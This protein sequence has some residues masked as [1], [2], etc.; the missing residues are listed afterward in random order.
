[1]KRSR[2]TDE[3]NIGIL[4]NHQAELSAAGMCRMDGISDATFYNWRQKHGGM[5]MS[6]ARRLKTL[7]EENAKLTKLLAES[8]MD[9]STLRD[10]L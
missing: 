10:L 9:V 4:K 2:F 6:E 8:I 3:Q 1:M 7:E 5:E